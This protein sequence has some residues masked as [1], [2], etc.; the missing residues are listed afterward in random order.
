MATVKA[1]VL[2]HH[3]KADGTYNVKIRVFH[4]GEKTFIDT[5]QFVGAKRLTMKRQIKDQ[6][7]LDCLEKK[8]KRYRKLISK[9]DYRIDYFTAQSIKE[10][11]LEATS[12]NIDFIE[13]CRGYRSE[14]RRVGQEN[15]GWEET[16]QV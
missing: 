16:E 3:K 14:E 5:V 9:L 4:K 1:V 12:G 10:Y 6:I 7:L 2:A 13:F 11:L 8:L 15:E